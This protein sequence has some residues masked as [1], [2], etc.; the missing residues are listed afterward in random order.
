MVKRFRQAEDFGLI[1]D[2]DDVTRQAPVHAGAAHLV[3]LALPPAPDGRDADLYDGTPGDDVF[4]GGAGDDILR[5]NAG[6]DRLSGGSGDDVLYG[7]SNSLDPDDDRL[8]GNGGS[9]TLHGSWGNDILRGGLGNDALDGGP[10]V[11]TVDYRDAD[12]DP[13][14]GFAVIADL[15]TVIVRGGAVANQ[16]HLFSVEN[17]VG[18]PYRDVLRGDGADNRLVGLDGDD[19]LLGRG[20]ADLLFGGNGDDTLFGGTDLERDRMEGGA[21]NDTFIVSLRQFVSETLEDGTVIDQFLPL[22][23]GRDRIVD[24]TPG[25]DI[26]AFET[27]PTDR[28][29][30]DFSHLMIADGAYQGGLTGAVIDFGSLGALFLQGVAAADLDAADF[31]FIYV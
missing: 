19:A 18:S 23:F 22:A 7:G 25:Q 6:A 20:G 31:R 10:G 4:G 5:G 26:V 15:E 28:L 2:L 27:I 1:S 24:F 13:A 30:A 14:T 3:T 29:S 8:S 9:D 17:I 16:D 12:P 11:D 21:G